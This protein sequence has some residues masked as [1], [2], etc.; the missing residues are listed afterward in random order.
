MEKLLFLYEIGFKKGVIDVKKEVSK[1]SQKSSF[2]IDPIVTPKKSMFIE[3]KIKRFFYNAKTVIEGQM[4]RVSDQFIENQGGLDQVLTGYSMGFKTEKNNVV[5]AIEES[6]TD[7]RGQ[8]LLDLGEQVETVFYSAKLDAALC[9]NCAPFDG[10]IFTRD[11]LSAEGLSFTSPVNPACQG[12]DNCR[13]QIIA[14]SLGGPND[15]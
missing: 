10:L 1:L 7:G 8:T 14:Y 4:E 9:D 15:M 3:K 13:C 12:G 6:Y 2:A 5:K 11:E